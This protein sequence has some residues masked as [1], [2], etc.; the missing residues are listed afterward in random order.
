MYY[1]T[2]SVDSSKVD[3]NKK[4]CC[5]NEAALCFVCQ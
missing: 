5:L 3:N 1:K 2:L 4:L